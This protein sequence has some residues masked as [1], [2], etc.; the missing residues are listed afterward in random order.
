MPTFYFAY[1]SNM[2]P[3]RV[4]ERG[5]AFVSISPARLAGFRLVFDKVSVAHPGRSH[6]NVVFAPGEVVEGVLYGLEDCSEIHKMDRFERA[7]INYGREVVVVE[8]R[9]A[10]TPAWTYF[11]NPAV[12]TPGLRPPRDYLEHLLAGREYLS[13]DYF[14]WLSATRCADD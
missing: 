13:R 8:S 7:P 3:V 1:G 10:R 2:N 11:A 4:Q 6:A 5:L 12:R 14:E 9:G